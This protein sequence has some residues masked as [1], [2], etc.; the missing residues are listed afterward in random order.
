MRGSDEAPL[1]G[2]YVPQIGSLVDIVLQ[3]LAIN[4]DF[5]QVYDQYHVYYA[6]G[7]LKAGLIRWIGLLNDRGVTIS[8]LKLLLLP[9]PDE[10]ETDVDLPAN[11]EVTYLELS[12]SLGHSIKLK[13]VTTLLFPSRGATI[14]NEPGESWDAD[15]VSP[16]PPRVLLPNLTHLSL[17]LHPFR[18]SGASWKSLLSLAL[19]L[20]GITHLSLAYWPEPC[21]T[22]RASMSFVTTPQGRSIPYGGTSYYSHSLDH[23]WSEAALILRMLSSRLYA[24]EYLDLTGCSTWFKALMTHS[25][26]DFVDWTNSW[27][28]ITFL[29]LRI[30]WRL[31][32]QAMASDRAAYEE[33]VDVAVGVEKYIRAQR[34][35]RGK[36]ITVE[37]DEVRG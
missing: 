15:D 33:A 11:I 21:F 22:P 30:G 26:H 1:P 25:E 36:F 5:H 31:G 20:P 18:Q 9:P 32:V 7:H 14:S 12:G 27:G 29:K 28:K 2:T 4:W 37:T 3:R 34:A 23:D 6:P 19:N 13:D 35:G 24:L 17:A 16:S 10:E 8:D